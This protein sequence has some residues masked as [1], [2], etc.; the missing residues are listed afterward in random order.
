M[1]LGRV[2][3]QRIVEIIGGTLSCVSNQS[4]RN[5]AD[6][7]VMRDCPRHGGSR[8]GATDTKEGSKGIEGEVDQRY[9]DFTYRDLGML[10]R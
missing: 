7:T 5:Y 10:Q 3:A 4:D 2:V 6:C 1:V 9:Q 8:V